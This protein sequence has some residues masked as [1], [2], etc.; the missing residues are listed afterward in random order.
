MFEACVDDYVPNCALWVFY[1]KGTF[2]I[3]I[4]SSNVPQKYAKFLNTSEYWLLLPPLYSKYPN[5]KMSLVVSASAAPL[6]TFST[7]NISGLVGVNVQFFVLPAGKSPIEAFTLNA[8][9]KASLFVGFKANTTIIY[10]AI[11]QLVCNISL[12]SS[13][14]GPLDLIPLI[15]AILEPI[16]SEIPV[17]ANQFLATGIQIPSEFGFSLVNPIIS[18]GKGS[19]LVS[20]SIKYVPSQ[21]RFPAL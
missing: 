3:T 6:V 14:I 1:N 10:G 21:G 20:S 15:D 18:I 4:D 7:P 9:L 17:L 5:M 19:L 2:S 8:M 12:V 13:N 16:C 11:Q